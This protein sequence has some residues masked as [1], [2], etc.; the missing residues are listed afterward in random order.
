MFID[1]P[2]LMDQVVAF[3]T[4]ASGSGPTRRHQ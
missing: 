3:L 1:H 2:E 4:I